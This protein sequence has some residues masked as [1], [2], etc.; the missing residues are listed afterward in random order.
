M[1]FSGLATKKFKA[2]E[3]AELDGRQLHIQ[4][5]LV[6][7]QGGESEGERI[8]GEKRTVKEGCDALPERMYV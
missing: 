8:F 1:S 5:D 2:L 4:L 7:S 3:R 6:R